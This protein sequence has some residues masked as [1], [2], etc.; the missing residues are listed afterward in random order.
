ML[1]AG[2]VKPGVWVYFDHRIMPG[3]RVV[4]KDAISF[5]GFDTPRL[6]HTSPLCNNTRI[7]YQATPREWSSIQV[8]FTQM[9]PGY[10]AQHLNALINTRPDAIILSLYGRGTLADQN[11]DLLEALDTAQQLNII[12]VAVSQ[13]YNGSIDFSVYA[14]GSQLTHLGVLSGRDITLEA[15]YTKLMVLFRLGYAGDQ[16]KDLFEQVLDHEMS[17]I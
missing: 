9:V 13:C 7:D 4:K 11:N 14:T 8:V 15:A 12:V 1:E 5:A 3:A 2:Q 16:V 10:S 17:E 6:S